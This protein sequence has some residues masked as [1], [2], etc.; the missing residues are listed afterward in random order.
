MNFRID[1]YHHFPAAGT[2]AKLDALLAKLTNMETMMP[3]LDEVLAKVTEEST[4]ID[5]L[6]TL[7]AGLKQQLA[8]ALADVN[9]TPEQQAK[10]DAI[11]A[12][13]TGNE[14]KVVDAID[15]NT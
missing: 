8:D 15:A 2:D 14:Q 13:I 4:K 5:S 10:V 6:A 1:I 11:F 12:G 3:T 9:L 7:T